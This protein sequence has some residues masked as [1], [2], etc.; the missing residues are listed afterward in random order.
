MVSYDIDGEVEQRY[1]IFR[2]IGSG[3]YG[4]VWCALDTHTGKQVALKKV[5]DAFGNQQ[6]AQRTYREVMLLNRLGKHPRMVKILNVMEA[7]NGVDLYIA[8]ELAETDLTVVLR[9]GGI[10]RTEHCCYIMYQLIKAVAQLHSMLVIHRDLKPSNI[11]INTDCSIKIGDFGLARC[12][13]PNGSVSN[14]GGEGDSLQFTDYIATRWYRSP[15]ILMRSKRYTTAM[16]MWAVGC[17]VC[18]LLIGQPLLSGTSTVHQLQLIV[19]ALGDPSE[20]DILSLESSDPW[21][22]RP[23]V[24]PSPNDSNSNLNSTSLSPTKVGGGT[25]KESIHD[26]LSGYDPL[27]IDLAEKLIVFNPNRR[28]TAKEALKHPYIEE[29]VTKEDWK[30]LEQLPTISLPLPDEK[31]L[32]AAEYKKNI[33]EIISKSYRYQTD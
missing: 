9:K 31:L 15:E 13:L 27:A 30:E 12:F 4:V 17:I 23:T 8:F 11:F 2:N 10:I 1:R 5:F 25:P 14:A 6:D 7:A 28:L 29:F 3:A 33:Y 24:V 22:L 18:E 16:D 26:I 21:P 19:D 32:T 20:E